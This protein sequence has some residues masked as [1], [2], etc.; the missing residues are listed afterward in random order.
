M[1][2]SAI[3]EPVESRRA[4]DD[5]DG[6]SRFVQQRRRLECTL[7]SAYHDHAL[8]LEPAE[9]AVLRRMGGERG[10]HRV[11]LV[12]PTGER[13]DSRRNNDA[14]RPDRLTILQHYVKAF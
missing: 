10:W 14:L 13:G 5:L 4:Y 8:T 2:R 9:I 6:G 1:K 3:A 11:E 12:R 7:P